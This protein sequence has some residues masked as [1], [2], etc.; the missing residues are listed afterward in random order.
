MFPPQPLICPLVTLLQSVMWPADLFCFGKTL[1]QIS[2]Y[3]NS[4]RVTSNRAV[5]AQSEKDSI[6]SSFDF[7]LC[8]VLHV[9]EDYGFIP[10]YSNS[11]VLGFI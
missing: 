8:Q 9:I 5:V 1:M 7:I 10:Q 2:S 6:I 4:N 11:Q 3:I